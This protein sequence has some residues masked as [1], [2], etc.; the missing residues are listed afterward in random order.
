MVLVMTRGV[1]ASSLLRACLL[2]GVCGLS[3]C[4]PSQPEPRLLTEAEAEKLRLDE[5]RSLAGVDFVQ[6]DKGDPKVIGC[7]DGQ[8]EGL[9]DVTKYPNVAGCLGRWEGEKSLRLRKTGNVCGDDS[10]SCRVPSDV[11]AAGW[12]VC[13]WNGLGNDL[14]DRLDAEG[15]H[16]GTGPGKFVAAMSHLQTEELCP[17]PP[18][19]R[20]RFPCKRTGIGSEPVCCG[21]DCQFGKC[22][23]AVWLGETKISRGTA[24]GCGMANSSRNGGVL[25]CIDK[26]PA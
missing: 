12:H 3:S 11:C 1:V 7:A 19:D 22:R 2:V 6:S 10:K 16:K 21:D 23:D 14:R 9:A 25:C 4:M 15:C 24:E 20:T 17:P 18:D 26:L 5:P 8:R 13:G